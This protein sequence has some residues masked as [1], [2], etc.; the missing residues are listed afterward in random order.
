MKLIEKG[1]LTKALKKIEEN[2][3]KGNDILRNNYALSLIYSDRE[4]K[5][6]NTEKSY[7]FLKNSFIEYINVLDEKTIDKLNKI[8]INDSIYN[9]EFTEIC[10][11]ALEDAV[12]INSIENYN[13]YLKFYEKTSEENRIMVIKKRDIVAFN[14]AVISHTIDSYKYFIETYPLSIQIDKAWEQIYTIAFDDATKTNTVGSYREHIDKYPNS[15]HINSCTLKIHEISFQKAEQTHTSDGYY[16]FC[17]E[18]PNSI[19]YTN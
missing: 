18:F 6:Y 5:D 14:I 17:Q 9:I 15:P 1:K 12:S 8:P 11:L 19:Q 3:D 2:I 13:H 7:L 10:K 16:Q 4:F